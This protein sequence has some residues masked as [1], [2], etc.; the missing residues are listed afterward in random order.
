MDNEEEMQFY[1]KDNDVVFALDSEEAEFERG[2]RRAIQ[3]EYSEFM[4]R[5]RS[6][7]G[8]E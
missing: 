7:Y 1:N 2:I 5:M 8:F 6:Y 4:Y 3:R